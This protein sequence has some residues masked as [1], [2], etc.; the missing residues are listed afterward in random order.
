MTI[1]LPDGTKDT[2]ASWNPLDTFWKALSPALNPSPDA[3]PV[4]LTQP[5]PIWD[6]PSPYGGVHHPETKDA[7]PYYVSPDYFSKLIVPPAHSVVHTQPPAWMVVAN[8]NGTDALKSVFYTATAPVAAYAH[9]MIKRMWL[10]P[11]VCMRAPYTCVPYTRALRTYL[12]RAR[13]LTC[14]NAS[15][16]LRVACAT[17]LVTRRIS[18]TGNVAPTP[19]VWLASAFVGVATGFVSAFVDS[20]QRLQGYAQNADD[21]A[22]WSARAS[23]ERKVLSGEVDPLAESSSLWRSLV[24]TF[25]PERLDV[26]QLESDYYGAAK[27]RE[28]AA[29]SSDK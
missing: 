9:T 25:G 13:R 17:P 19:F 4:K 16:H 26:K 10:C 5:A 27:Q 24:G 20:E 14:V 11:R 7:I 2:S 23:Y 15:T 6:L 21:V 8:F 1:I 3:S 28:D 22:Y 12:T 29:T 18:I